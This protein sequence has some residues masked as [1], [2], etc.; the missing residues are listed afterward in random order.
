M[1]FVSTDQ[2]MLCAIIMAAHY[3]EIEGLVQLVSQKIADMMKGKSPEELRRTFNI[4][5]P[6]PEEEADIR[7]QLQANNYAFELPRVYLVL[8]FSVLLSTSGLLF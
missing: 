8:V 3:L 6:T 7:A 4:P 2:S 1:E 5:A